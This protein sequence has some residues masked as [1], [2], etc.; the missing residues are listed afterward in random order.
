M[1]LE[2]VKEAFKVNNL[3]GEDTIQTVIEND[4]IVPDT[5]PDIARVLLLDG[6]VFV[7]GCD[8]GTDRVVT[9]GCIVC[10]ILYISDDSSRSVKSIISNIPF[11]YTLDVPGVRSGMKCRAKGLIEH[12]DYNLLNGR[13]I[14]VKAILTLNCR[15][16]D[17]TEREYCS[18]ITGLED[19]QVLKENVMLNSFLGSNKVNYVIKEDLE[20]PSSKPTIAE[21]LK[22]DVKISG[23]DFKIDDG[24][25]IVR[26]DISVSTLYIADDDNRSLQFMENEIAFNQVVELDGANE[27][28]LID[29]DY[30][31]I[32]YKVEAVEDSDGELRNIRAEVNLNIYVDGTSSRDVEILSDAYS[33]KARISLEKNTIDLDEVF[34]EN[35]SQIIIKDVVNL[36]ECSPEVSEIFNVLSKYSVS[37]L[38]IEDERVIIE[39][40]VQNNLLYL[41][42]NDEQPIFNFKKD[43]PFKHEI[44]IKG[45]TKDMKPEIALDLEH[46][47]YSMVS[48]NQVEIRVVI[49]VKTKVDTKKQIP[50]VNKVFEAQLDEK[51]VQSMPSIIIYITQPEDSLWKI[52]KKYGTTVDMLMKVNNINERDVLT[53]GQ[54]ILVLR[55]VI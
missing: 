14:N 49:G 29:V 35:R 36:S 5:K 20:L 26:G 1:S 31:L 38:R 41:S 18:G 9:S 44:E 25:V 40:A 16:N 50:V 33:T 11:S 15:A 21:I 46:S 17:E 6:D 42:N 7:T 10:K 47:N 34:A 51:K 54:Q 27:D 24:K 13:K 52:A 37:D 23:K 3:I 30:D 22:N 48:S 4:I 32:A 45:A 28:T 43:I 53:V 2:L 8:T 39:G 12:M 19:I 55:K